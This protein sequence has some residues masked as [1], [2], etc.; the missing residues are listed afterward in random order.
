MFSSGPLGLENPQPEGDPPGTAEL[1]QMTGARGHRTFAG[2]LDTGDLGLGERLITKV[3][4]PPSGDFRDWKAIR[5]WAAE[6]ARELHAQ[7]VE[8]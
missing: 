4:H 2:K 7:T 5:G 3:V 6:I 8:A 1:I